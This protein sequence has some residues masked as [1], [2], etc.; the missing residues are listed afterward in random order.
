MLECQLKD[1]LKPY[2][3]DE[4]AIIIIKQNIDMACI[5]LFVAKCCLLVYVFV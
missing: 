5:K 4:N 1:L 2:L 3:L